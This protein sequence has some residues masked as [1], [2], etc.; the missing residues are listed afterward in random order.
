VGGYAA[1]HRSPADGAG[2]LVDTNLALSAPDARHLLRT[3]PG[4]RLAVTTAATGAP[5][6][7]FE[8]PGPGPAAGPAPAEINRLAW[9]W[10]AGAGAGGGS[11]DGG[12][13]WTAAWAAAGLDGR[14]CMWG[15]PAAE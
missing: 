6:A 12:G 15:R 14:I 8:Q 2:R 4:G 13:D 5:A 11:A 10:A 3:A 9:N 1:R 7:L